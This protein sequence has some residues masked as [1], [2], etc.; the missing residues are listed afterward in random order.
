M[1]EKSVSVED[2][3]IDLVILGLFRDLRSHL[4]RGF[5]RTGRFAGQR[6]RRGRRDRLSVGG[7]QLGVDVP[8][9]PTTW[10]TRPRGRTLTRPD[11]AL[12]R[13]PLA[14]LFVDRFL[15]HAEF[16][17]SLSYPQPAPVLPTFRR[18]YSPT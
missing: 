14:G 17:W 6:A 8:G 4:L 9:T 7:D 11:A 3:A 16:P 2:N 12:A 1:K 18:T 13:P 15:L 10:E 5:D